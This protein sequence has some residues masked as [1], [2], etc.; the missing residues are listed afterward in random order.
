L[1][2]LDDCANLSIIASASISSEEEEEEEEEN[3]R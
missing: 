2:S 3:G 1:S